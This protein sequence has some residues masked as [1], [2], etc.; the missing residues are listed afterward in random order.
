MTLIVFYQSQLLVTFDNHSVVRHFPSA[1]YDQ[2]FY[3]LHLENCWYVVPTP[4]AASAG[5]RL[6]HLGE[7]I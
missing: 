7:H 3:D 6:E 5:Q 1:L 4:L 2:T